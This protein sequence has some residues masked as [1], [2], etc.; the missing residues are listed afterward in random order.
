M[1]D[2]EEDRS[3]IQEDIKTE[4]ALQK[5]IEDL[6]QQAQ[7]LEAERARRLAHLPQGPPAPGT[8]S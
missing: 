5:E 1:Q 2:A 7:E 3:A 4:Q 6:E 8:G